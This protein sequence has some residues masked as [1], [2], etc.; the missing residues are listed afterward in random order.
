MSKGLPK[1]VT[2]KLVN[3]L[4][5][6]LKDAKVVER[7]AGLGTAPVSNVDGTWALRIRPINQIPAQVCARSL[8][9][10]ITTRAVTLR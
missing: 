10:G 9:G 4:Q 7:F 1:D 5:V 6:A 8:L 2:D 3:A